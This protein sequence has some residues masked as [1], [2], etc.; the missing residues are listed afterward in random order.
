MK[1]EKLLLL[2]SALLAFFGSLII[3]MDRFGPIHNLISNLPKWKNIELALIDLDNYDTPTNDGS[4][5]G[6]VEQGKPGFSD[7]LNVIYS[8]KPN[9]KN[10][11]II[12][13]AKNQPISIGGVPMKIVHVG[14]RGETQGYSLTTDYIFN[15]WI[16]DYREK[17]FLKIGLSMI[18][19][20]FLLSV[21]V[22]ILFKNQNNNILIIIYPRLIRKFKRRIILKR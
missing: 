19:L 9:L 3:V 10:R 13:I 20:S 22:Q 14:F 16:R 8:N 1:A 4:N 11:D 18:A 2:I 17:Y 5:V 6:M 15:E 21:F 12:V 7:F